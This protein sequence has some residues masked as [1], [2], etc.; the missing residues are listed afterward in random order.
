MHAADLGSL[1]RFL[2]FNEREKIGADLVLVRRAQ[3]VRGALVDFQGCALDE[4][5]LELA[6]IGKRNDLVVVAL[7]DERRYV[8]LL[9]VLG[10]I[11]LGERLDA[12]VCGRKTRHHGILL[13][14]QSSMSRR[15]PGSRARLQSPRVH[16]KP[17]SVLLKER[18]VESAPQRPHNLCQLKL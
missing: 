4:L 5:G 16:D 18:L 10:L 17:L 15:A 13:K 9:Q 12:E 3:T 11:R 6:G 7:N 14:R 8:E 2:S 1:P